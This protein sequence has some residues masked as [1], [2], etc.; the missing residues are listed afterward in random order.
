ME[1]SINPEHKQDVNA[2]QS[3]DEL[4]PVAS[5]QEP[6]L[7]EQTREEGSKASS[8]VRRLAMGIAISQTLKVMDHEL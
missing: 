1:K 5:S 4:K 2:R 7:E 8:G 3:R 6:H